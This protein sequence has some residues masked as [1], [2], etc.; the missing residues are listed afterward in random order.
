MQAEICPTAVALFLGTTSL[1][2]AG[3]CLILPDTNGCAHLETVD[4]VEKFSQ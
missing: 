3:L 4:D 2:A 1:V